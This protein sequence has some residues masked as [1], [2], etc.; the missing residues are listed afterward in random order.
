LHLVLSSSTLIPVKDTR[1]SMERKDAEENT[2]GGKNKDA[3]TIAK[4]QPPE[5]SSD[6][7]ETL[8]E[9]N[10][11]RRTSIFKYYDYKNVGEYLHPHVLSAI[12]VILVGE[13]DCPAGYSE[14][15][16]K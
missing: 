3:A 5:G 1:R 15:T 2:E 7:S 4:R 14:G 16:A 9:M 10:G 6:N 12:C 13:P 8:S 11:G